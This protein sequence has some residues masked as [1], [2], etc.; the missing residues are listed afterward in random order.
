MQG[1]KVNRLSLSIE[2][3]AA[4]DG[5]SRLYGWGLKSPAADMCRVNRF[6]LDC[7]GWVIGR[8]QPVTDISVRIGSQV[9]ASFPVNKVHPERAKSVLASSGSGVR[10]IDR[11]R[12]LIQRV[13]YRLKL[14]RLTRTGPFRRLLNPNLLMNGFA[15]TLN[16]LQLPD[17][18][19]VTLN[20]DNGTHTYEVAR[21]RISR[22]S[23]P[24]LGRDAGFQPLIVTSIGR[25][26]ST[27]FQH[28]LSQHP[29]VRAFH[30][31]SY[32][33]V[34]ARAA[35]QAFAEM[36]VRQPLSEQFFELDGRFRFDGLRAASGEPESVLYSPE[37]FSQCVEQQVHGL[38]RE[39]IN[40]IDRYYSVTDDDR[41]SGEQLQPADSRRYMTE[42]NMAP[43]H[44][45]FELYPDGKEIFLVRDFRDVATSMIAA[46][47]KWN[48][49]FF[50]RSRSDSDEEMFFNRAKQARPWL[51][52]PW[53]RR[54]SN[55]LLVRYE[56]VISHPQQTVCRILEYL[57]LDADPAVADSMISRA[58]DTNHW[59]GGS[60]MTAGSAE[61]SIGRWKR[62]LSPELAQAATTAFAEYLEAFGYE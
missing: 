8:H 2:D 22:P 28:L 36:T 31:G 35:M 52:E 33:F 54:G 17:E 37:E 47:R 59:I 5:D 50:G 62:D 57:E 19:E 1:W 56:D 11:G 41:T 3:V 46:N 24:P 55:A 49:Q 29:A 14:G 45:F 27:W 26:G 9:I 60:H 23:L 21:I 10:L 39:A 58:A 34:P 43:A 18:C 48:T 12:L 38:L 44:L 20:A 13:L 40:S 4:R 42:K 7:G 6:S 25:S 32:E 53:M 61:A 16:L 51:L 15:G 30:G